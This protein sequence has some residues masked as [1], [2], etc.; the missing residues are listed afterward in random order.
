M[1][2]AFERVFL[3]YLTRFKYEV[4]ALWHIYTPI[5]GN[6]VFDFFSWVQKFDRRTIVDNH[7]FNLLNRYFAYKALI[8]FRT[9]GYLLVLNQRSDLKEEL[10]DMSMVIVSNK[11]G[12]KKQT[13]KWSPHANSL[14][15]RFEISMVNPFCHPWIV[16]GFC[17]LNDRSFEALSIM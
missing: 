3:N 7:L 14:L 15:I 12:R 5:I 16:Q 17:L 13:R 2:L 4:R 11:D 8:L 10:E 6:V 1:W 9:D